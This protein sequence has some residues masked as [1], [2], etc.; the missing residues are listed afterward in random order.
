MHTELMGKASHD[1]LV[2]S[3]PEIRPFVLTR[4]A[5]A[6]TMRYAASTW[7]GDNTTSW[8]GM[9]GANSLSLNAGFSLLP[10]YG[11]D[12][13]GFEGP[14]PTPE[15]LLRWIQLGVHSP[16][17]TINCF[18]T[19]PENN[20]VGDIIEP[21]M[22]PEI[23]PLVRDTI[24]RR[25]EIMPYLYSLALE[26]HLTAVPPQ[27][28]SGWGYENDPEVWTP[29]LLKGEKQYWLGDALLIGGVYESGKNTARMYLPR[30][31][32][33]D[34]ILSLA[35]PS[36]DTEPTPEEGY[37]NLNSP[38]QHLPAGAWA[39]ILSEWKMSI[40]ILAKIGTAIPVGKPIA[41]ASILDDKAEFPNLADDDWRGIEVFPPKGGLD[42]HI[43]NNKWYE[44]DGLSATPEISSFTI[45]YGSTATEVSVQIE[46]KV[47]VTGS[48]S[49]VPLWKNLDIILPVGDGRSVTSSDGKEVVAAGND[50]RG[51][52]L[53]RIISVN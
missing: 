20:L 5:T 14:Q 37:I 53:F 15:L 10:S 29:K 46:R 45:K 32:Y 31:A 49:F 4:S 9:K 21:W 18:K 6:G 3:E 41:T 27:R 17:F 12:I 42:G 22:Y 11:H 26:S 51:R 23:T 1:A 50:A 47:E 8:E 19:S 44:D 13:G 7:S 39:N 48:Q 2:D 40:P 52:K 28:W 36:S 38:Y 16:R 24:K 34:P 33:R 35:A 25:Y 43:Y 30:S